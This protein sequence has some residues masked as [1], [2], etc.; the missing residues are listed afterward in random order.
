MKRT[1]LYK[2][3]PIV[4]RIFLAMLVPTILM[5]LT[6]A[7]GSVAD[8]MI[9]GHY[10][11]DLSLSVV[12]FATPIYMIINTFAA[13]FAVGGCIA[14]SIDSG[15]GDRESSSR[16]F[17]LSIELL[18]VTGILLFLSGLFFSS[19]VTH[20]LGAGEEVFESVRHYAQI[21][22]LGAPIFMLNIG[23]AFFVRND[24]RPKLSMIGM[25]S[26]I[27]VD[28]ILNFVFVGSLG[29]GVAGAAYSTVIG[30]LVS[31]VLIGTHF[32]SSKNT[33][34]FGFRFDS[35]VWRIVKNGAS[36]ALHFVYQ[37]VTILIINHF[38][39]KLAGAESI[40]VYA[41]VFNLSTVSLSVFEGISQTIQPMI[42][43]YYGEKSFRNIKETLYHAIIAI[44]L[45][46][47]GVTLF[48]ELFPKVV[49]LCFGIDAPLLIEKSVDAVRIFAT[50]MIVMT[51][52]VVLGYYL[53]STERNLM[54]TVIISL[55]C[56]A[57]FLG[58]TFVLGKLFQMNGVWAAYTVAEVLTLLII[59]LMLRFKQKKL[60]KEGI[61]ANLLLLDKR[62]EKNTVCLTF[63]G[64]TDDFEDFIS[65]VGNAMEDATLSKDTK[66]YLSVLRACG[67]AKKGSYVQVEI[68]QTEK[69]VIV[70]DNLDHSAVAEDLRA[71]VSSDSKSDYGPVLGWNRICL[72]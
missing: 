60:K 55:R 53:Q 14:M 20:W 57:L 62:T 6:T 12:T 65:Q 16:A 72:E 22:L 32:F 4:K 18:S 42:S 64:E 5:N 26:S 33:L 44:L 51:L 56:F 1:Y 67:V 3:D 61:C 15:K 37:F 9:I 29:M 11:D 19:T 24:G 58:A 7:I 34:R 23:L 43:N 27:V 68:N 13:L 17:S 31:V 8:T 28:I 41:V 71:A 49:P 39:S 40:V 25:F 47:G 36:S 21:I 48:L 59:L 10:L 2:R 69:K 46:C 63:T 52:N 38:L 45:I 35:T 50:S 54:A 30:Q 70:R 66:A